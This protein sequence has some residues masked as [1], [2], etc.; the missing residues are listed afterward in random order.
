MTPRCIGL[1]GFFD[2]AGLAVLNLPVEYMDLAQ[3]KKVYDVD[4]N[5]CRTPSPAQLLTRAVVSVWTRQPPPACPA[6]ASC[7]ARPASLHGQRDG[8]SHSSLYGDGR[9]E[10]H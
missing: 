9:R 3:M 8:R 5:Q 1:V 6:A 7:F 2:S 4:G 10:S